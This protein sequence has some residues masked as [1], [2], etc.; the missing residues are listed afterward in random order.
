MK[1]LKIKHLI[2]FCI[3]LFN[4]S[5]VAGQEKLMKIDSLYLT[6]IDDFYKNADN[7]KSEIWNEMELAPICLFRVNGPALLYN[8]PNP[9][10]KFTQVTDKL[11]VG[12]Q[13]DLQLFGSTQMEINGILTAIADYGSNSYYCIEEIYAVV[14]HE[15]HH[16]YQTNFIDQLKF[17]NPATLLTYPESYAN[18]AIKNYEQKI[19]FRMCFEQDSLKFKSLLNQF[20]S[21]RLK[22]EH[23][24]KTYRK[25]EESV[26]NVEGPAFYCE[27]RY[28]NRFC[29]KNNALKNNYINMHFFGILTSPYY[30]RNNLRERHLASGMAMCYILDKYFNNWQSDY[31]SKEISLYS[32]FMSRFN[33]Q[34]EELKID[35]SFFSLSN[36]HTQQAIVKHQM[37]Y[38]KFIN[39]P[40]T[41]ITLEFSETPKFEG[42]DPM[43]A[44][45]I[46]DSIILH[47][48]I[49]KLSNGDENKLFINYDRAITLI[50]KEIWFVK[51][52]NLFAT[53][54]NILIENKKIFIDTEK[55]NIA[56]T[57]KLKK[58]NENEIIF[59]CE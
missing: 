20:Y 19:L 51:K 31:Y 57:G 2:L 35:S 30:G 37:S 27:Y 46:N 18:D 21:C 49:L 5:V 26:E 12:K 23:I 42:F 59:N 6:S 54:E 3:F 9:P 39:Q 33:P 36:F 47:S 48:T 58:K 41:K 28:Y 7:A 52:V 53:K 11:Y 56:W 25:Y 40:G 43:N 16:V 24:I 50:D 32:Y 34:K 1:Q 4:I 14:F 22:R 10:K 15:L 55:I 45:S 38:D 44:E 8:H 17:D 29:S 13:S